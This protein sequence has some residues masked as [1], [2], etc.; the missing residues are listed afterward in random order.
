MTIYLVHGVVHYDPFASKRKD[1]RLVRAENP[2]EAERK[3]LEFWASKNKPGSTDTWA[4]ID[5]VA[6]MI[7]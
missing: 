3:Y 7:E 4:A 5:D 1:F 2:M 6:E